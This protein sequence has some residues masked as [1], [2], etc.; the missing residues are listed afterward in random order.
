MVAQVVRLSCR[1][2]SL[3]LRTGTQ[4]GSQ[5]GPIDGVGGN[6][7]ETVSGVDPGNNLPVN[8]E[9]AP[10]PPVAEVYCEPATGPRA[11]LCWRDAYFKE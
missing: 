11:C 1:V 4:T 9:P 8:P 10:L 7:P 2:N 3:V 6:N 5:T